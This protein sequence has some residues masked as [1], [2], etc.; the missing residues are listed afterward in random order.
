M[1]LARP[2]VQLSSPF[3][4]KRPRAF[5]SS[6]KRR[7]L[8]GRP[9]YQRPRPA[10][11]RAEE[12]GHGL[13]DVLSLDW[14]DQVRGSGNPDGARCYATTHPE[15]GLNDMSARVTEPAAQWGECL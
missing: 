2:A 5:R 6:V 8:S 11:S 1:P 7:Y 13:D 10:L 12:H 15:V 9:G 14:R 4:L 3:S